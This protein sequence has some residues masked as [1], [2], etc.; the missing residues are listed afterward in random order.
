M[1]SLPETLDLSAWCDALSRDLVARLPELGHIRPECLLFCLARSRAPGTCG[2]HARIVPLRF[3]GGSHEQTRRR[4]RYLE[5]FT[6]P[7]LVHQGREILYLI[8]LLVPR[9]LRLSGREKLATLIHEL[10]HVSERCDGDI[11]RFPGRNYA[12]GTSRKGYDR[13]VA[14]LLSRYLDTAPKAELLTPLY[15]SE[16]DWL[17]RRVRLSGLRVPMPRARLVNRRRL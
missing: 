6:L 11:R 14:E 4:G 1:N 16:E 2:V 10:Y 5:T 12:H 17:H 15:L 7:P 9:F 8:H 3:A 13:R